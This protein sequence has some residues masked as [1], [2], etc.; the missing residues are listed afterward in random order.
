MKNFRIYF[1]GLLIF[2]SIISF[3]LA[4]EKVSEPIPFPNPLEVYED[5]NLIKSG[6]IF[7]VLANRIYHTPFNIWSSIIFCLQLFILFLHQK[8]LHWQKDWNEIIQKK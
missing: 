3:V 8:L 2:G 4:S 5:D 7:E 6:N 1:L